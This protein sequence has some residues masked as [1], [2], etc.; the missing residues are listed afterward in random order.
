MKSAFLSLKAKDLVKG[1][2]IAIITAIVT[3]VYQSIDAGTFAL[4]WL[5]FKP[6]LLTG[7]GAG[8]SYLLKNWL[9]NSDD[10]FLKPEN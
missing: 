7:L 2:I 1:L 4:T 5:Y 6:I 9:T 8:L 3:G 10:K